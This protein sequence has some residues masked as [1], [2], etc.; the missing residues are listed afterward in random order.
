MYLDQRILIVSRSV[1]LFQTGPIPVA[2]RRQ[3]QKGVSGARKVCGNRPV[4]RCLT[5][6]AK[7]QLVTATKVPTGWFRKPSRSSR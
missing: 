5:Q 3:P 1:I 6:E 7:L 4:G 2:R